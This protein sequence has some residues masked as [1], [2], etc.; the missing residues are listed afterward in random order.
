[1]MRS[2]APKCR[3]RS[4]AVRLADVADA[5]RDTGSAPASSACSSRCAATRFARALV[6]HALEAAPACVDAELVQVGQRADQR[7]R[8]PAGRPAC[9][10]G[11][12]CPSR[13]APAKCRIACL[14][15]AA[16]NRPPVQRQSTSPSSRTI[17]A[18]ADRALAAACVKVERARRRPARLSA[19]TPTTSGITSPARRTITVSPM[20]TS[21]RR[22]LVLV[23]QGR[24]AD[25]R[26]ADEH[27]LELGHRRQLAGAADLDVDAA[28][29]VICSC[30]GYLCATAQRGSRDY[31]A[32]PLLQ[33]A[34]V[35]LVDHAV[36][37]ERQRV[38]LAPRSPAWKA[39]RPAAPCDH[40]CARRSTGRPIASQRVEQCALRARG[41]LPAAAPRRGRRRRSSAAACA[42][43]AGSSWR[44]APA[45]ALRGL[46]KVFS[47]FAPAAI[48][49]RWRSL[50]A[51]KSSR[52]M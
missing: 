6:G 49:S 45:A 14:R 47:F 31:E 16:Q 40:A 51:S 37:V 1:M 35:D 50:S 10:P 17:V 34:V 9:R 27:R 32:E 18:A 23:V 29:R 20:R 5:E 38:A 2:S 21:L 15:C 26:A 42:A 33:R 25:R 36:D 39:T 24:V 8:R 48:S 13:A 44:T 52:R 22:A 28:Q 43:I 12:R 41:T 4:F 3:A 46:T 7:R 30:A 11:P 19:T